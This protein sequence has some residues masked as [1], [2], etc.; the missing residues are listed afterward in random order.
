MRSSNEL[1]KEKHEG[2]YRR[3]WLGASGGMVETALS[4]EE[5]Q[6]N[7]RT[8]RDKA[9]V[10]AVQQLWQSYG[11]PKPSEGDQLV[12]AFSLFCSFAPADGNESAL[13]R[14]IVAA[15]NG[16]MDCFERAATSDTPTRAMELNLAMRL[17][18]TVA[19]LSRAL[20]SHRTAVAPELG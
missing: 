4:R 7:R 11:A 18:V 8:M 13:S 1:Q 20:D 9:N 12:G 17:S 14:L 3:K 15:T 10:H 5:V 19:A 6:E 2:E 16:A